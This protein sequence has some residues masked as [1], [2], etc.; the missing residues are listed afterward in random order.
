MILGIRRVPWDGGTPLK[1]SCTE[2]AKPRDTRNVCTV[3][4]SAVA[5]PKDQPQGTVISQYLLHGTG[6]AKLAAGHLHEE[7]AQWAMGAWVRA[8][9]AHCNSI[10]AKGPVCDA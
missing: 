7:A 4:V 9:P 3:T 1:K 2:K 10:G 5:Q 8:L 6:S